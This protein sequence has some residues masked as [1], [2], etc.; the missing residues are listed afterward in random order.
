[1]NRILIALFVS[2]FDYA[3]AAAVAS[4]GW[5]VVSPDSAETELT[6]SL[7]PLAEVKSTDRS[8]KTWQQCGVMGGTVEGALREFVMSLGASGWVLDKT[9]VLGHGTEKSELMIWTRRTRRILF[10]VWEKEPGTCGF[11]WGKEK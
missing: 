5:R 7:P 3:S 4:R 1:M 2:L 6:L 9:I 11:A 8:G 10:M